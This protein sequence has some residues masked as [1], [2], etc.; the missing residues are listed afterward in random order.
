MISFSLEKKHE[1][2]NQILN[3]IYQ[4]YQIFM[5]NI[6]CFDQLDTIEEIFF[7]SLYFD[8]NFRG[9]IHKNLMYLLI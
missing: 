8:Y 9:K 5:N 4:F 1:L 6:F 7:M 2:S 3:Q